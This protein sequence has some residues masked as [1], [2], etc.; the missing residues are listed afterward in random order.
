MQ[1]YNREFILA[2][3]KDESKDVVSLYFRPTD[4]QSYKFI[5]GQ[6]VDIK[7]S[8][9]YGRSKSYTISSSDSDNL[10]RLTIK[11]KGEVSSALID[12]SVGDKLMFDGPYGNFYPKKGTNEIVMIAGG[13][14]IT[15]FYSVIKSKLETLSLIH[16]SE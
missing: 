12:L 2:N 15:P 8:S 5:P 9:I 1:K 13:V 11:R 4:N 16:I 10:T 14:G 3:K 7:L 6:Y